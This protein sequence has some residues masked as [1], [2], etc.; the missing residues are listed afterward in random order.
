MA[1]PGDVV[2]RPPYDRIARLDRHSMKA[3]ALLVC[4]LLAP[5]CA[6][7]WPS[8]RGPGATGVLETSRALPVSC[9]ATGKRHIAWSTAI[10]GLSPLMRNKKVSHLCPARRNFSIDA[11]AS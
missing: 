11:S 7:N 9:D 2:G 10:P 1:E 4:A 5:A 3:F 6:Q 8:F